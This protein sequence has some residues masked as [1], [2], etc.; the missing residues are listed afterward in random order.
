[1]VVWV[2]LFV[3]FLWLTW[4]YT[5]GGKEGAMPDAAERIRPGRGLNEEPYA[6]AGAGTGEGE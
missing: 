6:G 3:V 5:S 1:V 4:Y 2:T